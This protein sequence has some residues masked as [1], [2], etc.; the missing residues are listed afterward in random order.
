M[1]SGMKAKEFCG[2]V[3]D[4]KDQ[5]YFNILSQSTEM[6]KFNQNRF[7]VYQTQPIYL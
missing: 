3:I 2:Q 1:E 4:L 7:A 5:E 6:T